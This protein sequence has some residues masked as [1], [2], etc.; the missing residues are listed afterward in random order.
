MRINITQIPKE[1]LSLHET[2]DGASLNLNTP[3]INFISPLELSAQVA[4]VSNRLLVG[5]Q[6]K[7]LIQPVC[8]RCLEE[9]ETDFIKEFKFDYSF[10]D[11][12]H[13]LDITDDIRQEIT[14]SYPIKFLCKDD[15]KGLCPICGQN[16]NK[17]DCSHA[18]T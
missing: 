15:C 2:Y 10:R 5:V 16:L 6:V 12:E 13:I 8:S 18:L 3:E 9:F 14:L 17:G 11:N 4:K 7:G 1:G